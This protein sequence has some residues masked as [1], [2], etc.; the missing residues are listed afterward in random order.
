MLKTLFRRGAKCCVFALLT[1]AF[2]AWARGKTT[3][4][5]GWLVFDM[6]G[7][8]RVVFVLL[9]SARDSAGMKGSGSVRL[10]IEVARRSPTGTVPWQNFYPSRVGF[11]S[12]RGS[13]FPMFVPPR[14]IAVVLGWSIFLRDGILDVHSTATDFVVTWWC[15]AAGM[16]LFGI[17]R[18]QFTLC[19]NYFP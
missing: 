11:L 6:P 13:V 8:N 18:C 1:V 2:V 5:K 3:H 4:D 15:I 17:R 12:E 16:L 19:G 14:P 7:S 9:Q 10:S